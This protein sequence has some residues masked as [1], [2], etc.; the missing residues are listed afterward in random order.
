MPAIRL[1]LRC[2]VVCLES[3]PSSQP[4][5]DRELSDPNMVF[6]TQRI[7]HS[8][9]G[10]NAC[11]VISLGS[12]EGGTFGCSSRDFLRSIVRTVVSQAGSLGGRDAA[13]RAEAAGQAKDRL[14]SESL[15]ASSTFVLCPIT[16]SPSR[17]P[18]ASRTS[19]GPAVRG[20]FDPQKGPN[21][22]L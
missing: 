21:L 5:R 13:R 11:F 3:V 14:H 10:N 20:P 6:L 19:F 17:T 12:T 4:L 15:H 22:D 7:V 8:N 16:F 18:P 1:I 9:N 2:L